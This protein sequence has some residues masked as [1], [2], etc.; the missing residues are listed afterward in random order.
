MYLPSI[1]KKSGYRMVVMMVLA[2]LLATLFLPGIVSG[3]SE[4]TTLAATDVGTSSATLN[5]YTSWEGY[6]GVEVMAYFKYGLTTSYGETTTP[7]YISSPGSFSAQISGLTP[8]T[9]YHFKAVIDDNAPT[10]I[11]YGSDRT[12]TTQSSAPV[13]SYGEYAHPKVVTIGY[14]NVSDTSVTVSG[15][16]TSMGTALYSR[17]IGKYVLVYF[18]YGTEYYQTV[19]PLWAGGSATPSQTLTEPAEFSYNITDLKPGTKYY[20]RA[21]AKGEG[22]IYGYAMTFETL[23]EVK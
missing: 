6:D 13:A 9:T 4:V 7:T 8:G 10:T 23:P 1:I 22:T 18:K 15:N 12:F 3:N 11:H 5:G 14:A 17:S 2:L 19:Y 20:F 16:L 21:V